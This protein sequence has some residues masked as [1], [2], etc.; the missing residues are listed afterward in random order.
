MGIQADYSNAHFATRIHLFPPANPTIEVPTLGPSFVG[1][2]AGPVGAL[3][4]N[5]VHRPTEGVQ[6]YPGSHWLMPP[7]EYGGQYIISDIFSVFFFSSFF[8]VDP[9]FSRLW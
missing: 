4:R 5:Q 9:L 1:C 3:L 7:G 6:G 8:V 2:F